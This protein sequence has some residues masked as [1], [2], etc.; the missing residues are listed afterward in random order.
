MLKK[1][2]GASLEE[3]ALFWRATQ[4]VLKEKPPDHQKSLNDDLLRHFGGSFNT[5]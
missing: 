2:H 3:L 5:V 1:Q 4:T